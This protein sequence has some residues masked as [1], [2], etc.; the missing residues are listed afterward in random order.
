[1]VDHPAI[2]LAAIV[3]PVWFRLCRLRQLKPERTLMSTYTS[4]YQL[5]FHRN[6]RWLLA[7]MGTALVVVAPMLASVIDPTVGELA[8]EGL[9]F[10]GLVCGAFS[11]GIGASMT[12]T[13]SA[14]VVRVLGFGVAVGA[15]MAKLF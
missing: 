13:A 6:K 8:P 2:G 1:M 10:V 5:Y 15:L 12:D 3:L 14:R 4:P 7:A 11:I 9:V